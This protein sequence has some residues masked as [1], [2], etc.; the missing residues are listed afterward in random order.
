VIFGTRR[1]II[2]GLLPPCLD[3]AKGGQSCG[4]LSSSIA[5]DTIRALFRAS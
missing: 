5:A 1:P 3:S 2:L 4:G